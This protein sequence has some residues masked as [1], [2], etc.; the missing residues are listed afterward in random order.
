MATVTQTTSESYVFDGGFPVDNTIKRAYDDADLNRAV[1]LYR[2][3]FPSV[4]GLSIFK[5]TSE[6]GVTPNRVQGAFNTEPKHV[7]LTLN[8][9]TPYGPLLLDLREGPMVIELPPGPIMGV[10][11]DLN[12]RWLADMGIPGPE[13]GKGGRH[14]VTP[15]GWT[16]TVSG[17]YFV[18]PSTTNRVIAGIRAIPVGGDLD[19]A[20]A[21]IKAVQM[22]PLDPPDGWT[23]PEWV[24]LQD[25]PQD[26]TPDA[27]ENTVDY[28]RAVHEVIDGEPYLEDW[29]PLY[30]GLAALG[31]VKG[32]PF[33]PDARMTSILEEAARLGSG[34]LRVQ[35]F[36]DRR[37]DRVAWPDAHWE[38]AALRQNERFA[39]D[40]GYI[41]VTAR[42]KWF[43][44]AIGVSP[45]M[46]R[47]HAGAGSLYWLGL[48][49]AAGNYFDGGRSYKLTVPQPVPG[50]LFWSITVYDAET[51]SQIQT[52]QGKAALRSLF[53]LAGADTS[54]PLDLY[55]APEEP[56]GAAGRWI[57]TISGKGWF[58][59]FRIYGPAEPAFDGSWRLL[60]FEPID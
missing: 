58:V 23:A 50:K 60:D 48:R 39:S 7:G 5:G 3:F 11:M 53:E 13:A 59:F 14:L 20:I 1:E 8:S 56:D 6:V 35:A 47:R 28:W 34:Q 24:E 40:D 36:A 30:G 55:F 33:A 26:Q 27:V 19:A 51:R 25:K 21:L 4:S 15:P 31:I 57:K 43:F 18:V 44:Q 16:G 52:D 38:W 46:M 37:A 42:E 29:A 49:D 41:D 22:R 32:E 17:G 9:D 2:F 45:A 10:A 54:K 12:Q